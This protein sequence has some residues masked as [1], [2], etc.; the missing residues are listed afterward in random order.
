MPSFFFFL[1]FIFYFSSGFL[2]PAWNESRQAS[3]LDM[4]RFG[5]HF[6]RSFPVKKTSMALYFSS[7]AS[8]FNALLICILA[9]WVIKSLLAGMLFVHLY[10]N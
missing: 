10:L 4:M 5:A 8:V 6:L 9:G 2:A 3:I 7:F 1:S